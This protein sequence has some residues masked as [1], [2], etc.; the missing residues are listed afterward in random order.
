MGEITVAVKGV[1]S[2]LTFVFAVDIGLRLFVFRLAF[3]REPINVL[4]GFLVLLD[5]VLEVW[6]A[7][8]NLLSALK[9]IRFLRLGRILRNASRLRDLYLMMMGMVASVRAMLFG[10]LMMVLL[11]TMWSTMTV[12][13]VRPVVHRIDDAG[14]FDSC[15]YC[16]RAFDDVVTSNLTLVMLIVGGDGWTKLAAPLMRAD[17]GSAVIICCA[18]VTVNLGLLN[19]I[20]AVIVDKQ[21]QAREED[22]ELGAAVQ[23][24]ELLVSISRLN[25][26][27]SEIDN[28][29]DNALDL[30]EM[31]KYYDT[32]DQ[33]RKVLNG[34][35]CH[36]ADLPVIFDILDVDGGGVLSFAEFVHGLHRLQ[37]QDDHALNVFTKHYC[38]KLHADMFDRIDRDNALNASISQLWTAF[39]DIEPTL[40]EALSSSIER[41]EKT[42]LDMARHNMID[43]VPRSKPTLSA[44]SR[45]DADASP[46][47]EKVCVQVESP[48]IRKTKTDLPKTDLP[49]SSTA[50]DDD[51]CSPREHTNDKLFTLSTCPDGP[52]MAPASI[53]DGAAPAVSGFQLS[54]GPQRLTADLEG[55]AAPRCSACN[56]V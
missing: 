20:A 25:T 15:D 44:A 51:Q 47:L 18:F 42:V 35:D 43:N 21:A 24:E 39:N 33:F 27:F 28:N 11:V 53:S 23:R 7:M 4:E 10:T 30:N 17:V 49:S 46:Q 5:V 3:F 32:S 50:E 12:S 52:P 55:V 22:D 36:K 9:V 41:L 38:E 14:L 29:G 37:D 2:F 6:N 48:A 19:T 16:R 26:V 13:F 45:T 1:G 8:P 54:S 40:S 31:V 56:F 34:M